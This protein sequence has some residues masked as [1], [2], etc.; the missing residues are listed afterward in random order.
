MERKMSRPSIRPRPVHVLLLEQDDRVQL[1]DHWR[2]P[3]VA[4]ISPEKR[5]PVVLL[6]SSPLLSHTQSLLRAR[7]ARVDCLQ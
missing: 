1:V 6:A 5:I 4:N 2:L 7:R 3:A